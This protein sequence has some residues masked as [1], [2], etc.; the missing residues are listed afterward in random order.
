[1][2]PNFVRSIDRLRAPEDKKWHRYPAEI[3]PMWVADMDFAA[4]E[5][6]LAA[7][8]ERLDH[9]VLGYA[10]PPDS[11][12]E[13]IVGMLLERHGWSVAPDSL[14]FLPG[15]DPGV[16]MA[17]RANL[18]PGDGVLIQTPLYRPLLDAPGHWDLRRIEV[19]MRPTAT[20]FDI[21]RDRLAA[22]IAA[23]KAFLLCNPHNPTGRVLT[24]DELGFIGEGCLRND[25]LIIADEVHC[26]LVYS[27]HRHIPIA[28]LSPEVA[29]R[30]ITLM[31]ASKTFNIPGLKAAFAIITDP[32]LRRR[33]Q[34]ARL[35][36]VDSNN[37]LGLVGTEAAYRHAEGW[38]RDLVDYLQQNRDYLAAEIPRRLPGIRF[39]PPEASYLAWLD[40]RSLALAPDPYRFFLAQAKVGFSDGL[41]FG[42]EGERHVRMNFGAPRSVL[43]EALDRMERALQA[44]A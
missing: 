23:A 27:G 37:I 40:C 3:L 18:S 17:L 38:R 4:P 21:N 29:R 44:R 15:I 16:N 9:E 22:G 41:E 43:T 19:A 39:R 31:S 32:D 42:N 14:V 1:M 12:R 5:P 35:G 11:L 30:T 7:L 34:A 24:R 20:G 33:F 10:V 25:L 36:M 13:A 2:A 26:D 6:I 28:T 8:R